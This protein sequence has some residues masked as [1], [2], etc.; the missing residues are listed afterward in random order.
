MRRHIQSE[1]FEASDNEIDLAVINE[2][3]LSLK[4]K[5]G[6]SIFDSISLNTKN[7]GKIKRF[8]RQPSKKSKTNYIIQFEDLS[9]VFLEEGSRIRWIREESLS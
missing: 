6:K 4:D 8:F 1:S 2:S 3:G 7:N 5:S 9:L